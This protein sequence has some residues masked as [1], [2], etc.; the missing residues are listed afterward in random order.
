MRQR[1]R[2]GQR[3]SGSDYSHSLVFP[4]LWAKR[5]VNSLEGAQADESRRDDGWAD[6]EENEER[7]Q[8]NVRL[9]EVEQLPMD[10]EARRYRCPRR[11][12]VFGSFQQV[13]CSGCCLRCGIPDLPGV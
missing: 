4:R 6:R 8:G 3:T 1:A 2:S 5:L 11:H 7:R 12:L 10:S 9:A 13:I